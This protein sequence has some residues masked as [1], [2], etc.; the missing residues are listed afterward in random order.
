LIEADFVPDLEALFAPK[1]PTFEEAM[2]PTVGRA[3]REALR[4]RQVLEVV[5]G[6]QRIIALREPM[7][8]VIPV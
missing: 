2:E 8:R 3:R 7:S 5:C 1:L 4:V 6:V